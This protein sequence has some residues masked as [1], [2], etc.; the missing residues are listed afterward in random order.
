LLLRDVAS[1]REG[2][3]PGE[4]DRYNMRRVV[5]MTA[6]IEGEDLGRVVQHV[7]EAIKSAG[8]PPRGVEVD[9]RG[10]IEPFQEMFRGLALGLALAVAVIFLLLTAYFQSIR[11][12]LVSASAVPAVLAGVAVMLWATGTTL[13]IQ[14]FM[15]AIMAIGVAVSNAILLVT[16]AEEGRQQ[17]VAAG[18]AAVQGASSRLRPILMTSCAMLA[19]MVPMAL[20]LGEGGQQ[21]APLG[22]AVMGGLAASTLA[23]LTVLPSLFAVILGGGKAK[24]ASLDPDDP[25]SPHHT[26]EGSH[27]QHA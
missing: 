13:N 20:A 16:F 4:Y 2:T 19:G 8:E 21:M 18:E 17:G 9:V 5:S 24:S 25:Q 23:T 22:R 15:G 27:V 12:A 6:N 10:Q 11:L 3:M 1:I 26:P 14:S 7:N